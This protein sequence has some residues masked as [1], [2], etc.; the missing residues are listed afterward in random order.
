MYIKFNR[1][2]INE[3]ITFKDELLKF[4]IITE[5]EFVSIT[6][7]ICFLLDAEEVN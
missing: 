3:L 2:I 5:S 7:F 4:D 1:L 6:K